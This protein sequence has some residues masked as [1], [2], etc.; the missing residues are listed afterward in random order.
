MKLWRGERLDEAVERTASGLDDSADGKR[1]TW[2]D[3]LS[4][5]RA[6]LT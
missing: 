3:W 4:A 2:W 1:R 6:A 5:I